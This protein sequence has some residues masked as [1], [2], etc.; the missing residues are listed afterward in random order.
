MTIKEGNEAKR[1]KILL[2]RETP[3]HPNSVLAKLQAGFES[4]SIIHV[5]RDETLKKYST[6]PVFDNNYLVIFESLRV[7]ESNLNSI[8]FY[9][10]APVLVCTSKSALEDAVDL[11]REREIEYEAYY[12]EFTRTDAYSLVTSLASTKVSDTFFDAL[13]RRVGLSPQRILSAIMVC[14]QVGYTTSNLSKYID[15]Y[16][17]IDNQDIISS[18]LRVC[19]SK[20][21]AQR[22]AVYLHMNR[23]WYAKYTKGLLVDEVSTLITIFSDLISGELTPFSLHD[24]VET[25]RVPRYR[26]LYALDLFERVSLIELKMLRQ[27]LSSASMLEVAMKLS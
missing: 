16:V 3:L 11:M 27:F 7:L 25:K 9:Y 23:L 4:V 6:P 24:Y 12:N 14:E 15:K 5:F 22:A 19:K 17:Y 8:N 10:M 2:L 20:A 26:I 18:L 13:I 21:Q 1:N